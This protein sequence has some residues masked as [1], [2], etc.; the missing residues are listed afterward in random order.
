MIQTTD[1][2]NIGALYNAGSCLQY[3]ILAKMQNIICLEEQSIGVFLI[4][5]NE[6][7]YQYT[8]INPIKTW[9]T[10][11]CIVKQYGIHFCG[12]TRYGFDWIT[13][14]FISLNECFFNTDKETTQD[15][16]AGNGNKKKYSNNYEILEFK[17]IEELLTWLNWEE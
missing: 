1:P 10:I 14:K 7:R 15:Y 3:K 4:P 2:L 8:A 17:T 6:F 9:P 12:G 5:E 13:R 11:P 16:F